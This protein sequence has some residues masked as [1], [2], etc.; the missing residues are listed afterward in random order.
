MMENDSVSFIYTPNWL[1]Q[2]ANVKSQQE[3]MN[4]ALDC[5]KATESQKESVPCRLNYYEI[6]INIQETYT[7]RISAPSHVNTLTD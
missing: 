1:R 6:R 2:I 7:C 5:G 3:K 4:L